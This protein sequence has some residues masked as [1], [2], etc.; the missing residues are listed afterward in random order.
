MT[1]KQASLQSKSRRDLLEAIIMS[2]N[3]TKKLGETKKAW[4]VRWG[5]YD[6]NEDECLKRS[7]INEKVVDVICVRKDF[8]KYIVEI[9]KDIYKREMLSFSEKIS[10]S[11]YSNGEKRRKEFFGGAVP[12][13]THY[14]SD[15]YRN[16]MK[17]INEN[18]LDDKKVK[19]LSEK[20]SKYPQ[21]IT[22]GHNPYLEIIKVFN[23]S[24]SKSDNGN[25]VI[26]WD[27]PLADGSLKREKYEC[28]K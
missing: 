18:G 24:V 7:G 10:L 8:D 13:F 6:Q 11:N 3:Q 15:L 27:C 16:L 5:C 22:V 9:A 26:E 17:A 25:E 12:V 20:W 4:L 28:K 2:N 23:L 21:Y 1:L 19:N 14:Q